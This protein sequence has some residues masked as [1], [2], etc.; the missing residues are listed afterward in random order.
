[1]D[2]SRNRRKPAGST[3]ETVAFSTEWT[4]EE[5]RVLLTQHE[6][7]YQSVKLPYGLTTGGTDRSS[8]ARLIYPES[9][10]G[11]SVFDVGCMYGYFV[12]EA[13]ERGAE[14]CVGGEVDPANLAKCRLLASA[15]GSR[16]QFLRL[17]IERDEIPGIFDYVLCLN[18]LHHLRNP[19]A[20]LEK[21]IACTREC[22]VLEVASL[23]SH[24]SRKLGLS[25]VL[26]S[27]LMALLPILYLGGAGKAKG[28][29]QTFF[30]TE[31]AIRTL[32]KKHRQD[33][34]SIEFKRG[35]QKGRFI[36]VARKRRISHLYIVAG[37]NAVGKSTFLGNL[38]KGKNL[39]I[40]EEIGLDLTQP[41]SLKHYG[42]F[43]RDRE[44]KTPN[45][46]L[47]YNISKYIL[48]GDLHR[49]DRGLLDIIRCA[50]KVTIITFWH[51]PE[52]LF[53]RYKSE[54]VKSAAGFRTRRIRRKTKRLLE[55]YGDKA[56][57]IAI[58]AEWFDFAKQYAESNHV[59][60]QE[61][62]YRVI[63]IDAWEAEFGGG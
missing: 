23:T 21:L 16:A 39:E 44:A 25:A 9:L 8:T 58:Y 40:A 61:P 54:R 62:D 13:E 55:L 26:G 57:F 50:E 6:F 5:V 47:H 27:H 42:G 35:G 17:D 28:A 22:L 37:V 48:D 49:Y 41:W 63:S 24:D 29:G 7:T 38:A 14:N 56:R 45:L 31:S 18:V 59:V 11:K 36:V 20:V 34:A 60:L 4:E 53:D 32:F 51:P 3:S 2:D 19:L 52:R 12:F 30:F 33:F 15:R 10:A 46:L 1:M 43:A